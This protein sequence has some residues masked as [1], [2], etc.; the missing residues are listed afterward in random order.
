M[1][2]YDSVWPYFLWMAVFIWA[3]GRLERLRPGAVA[4]P[5][6]QGAGFIAPL[7]GFRGLLACSVF[8]HH[9]LFTYHYLTTGRWFNESP[10]YLHLGLSAVLA[11]FFMTGFLFWG[12]VIGRGALSPREFFRAR[13]RRLVPAHLGALL[14]IL[15]VVGTSTHWTAAESWLRL[16]GELLQWATF[17]VVKPLP[18]INHYSETILI[19]AGVLWSLRFEWYFYLLLPLLAWFAPPR[20]F[21][22]LVSLAA[23]A[24]LILHQLRPESVFDVLWRNRELP[25]VGSKEANALLN[26]SLPAVHFFVAGFVPGMLAAHLKARIGSLPLLRSRW[27]SGLPLLFLALHV[28]LV[29]PGYDLVSVPLLWLAFL[30]IALGCDVFGLLSSGGVLF[31]GTISYSWYLLHGIV[32]FVA[33]H[34][35]NAYFPF[36]AMSPQQYWLFVG[37][38]GGVVLL[39]SSASFLSLELPFLS[40]TRR[41]LAP[42]GEP[43]LSRPGA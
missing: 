29:P 38:V 43:A 41:T 36:R 39:V 22:A 7:E 10:F 9:A 25:T 8:F 2:S 1:V 26:W 34:V 33:A 6:S 35:L 4:L 3:A 27:L 31:L 16:A 14:L 28:T 37:V 20:R 12:R 18:N 11:F 32:L 17:G 13:G 15:L 30:S 21:A 24:L 5:G 40:R 23:V 42:A 19:N